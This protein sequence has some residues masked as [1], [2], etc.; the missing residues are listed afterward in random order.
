MKK[1]LVIFTF[2]FFL[3]CGQNNISEK[4]ISEKSQ[5][6][7]IEEIWT[8]KVEEKVVEKPKVSN[9][10]NAK[11]FLDVFQT[12]EVSVVDEVVDLEK[13]KQHN[14]NSLDNAEII[15]EYLKK[16]VQNSDI[17]QER[18]RI[19]EDWDFVVS[20]SL[21]E[22]KN[23]KNISIEI[24]KFE[25]WKVTD[26]WYNVS[27]EKLANISWEKEVKDLEK[28]EENKKIAEKFIKEF[29]IDLKSENLEK[30]FNDEKNR[31][32]N[33]NIKYEKIHKILWE[34][35]FVL[36]VSEW[37]ILEKK[38]SFYN[39]FRFEN[40]KIVENW[41]VNQEISNDEN[42]IKNKFWF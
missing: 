40:G 24:L 5:T 16:F 36:V 34:G 31:L 38:Y 4:N 42:S 32:S 12:W 20:H 22:L 26:F 21:I 28:T 29:F 10:E 41:L 7:K 9:I 8:S 30:Y 13:F 18:F 14:P 15:K 6:W 23:W 11:K 2:L 35:N 39:I 1:I 25:N 27:P 37:K 17:K 33:K 19:F 3:S